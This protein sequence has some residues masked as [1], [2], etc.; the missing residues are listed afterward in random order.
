MKC[1]L[2]KYLGREESGWTG[3]YQ[4]STVVGASSSRKFRKEVSKL[5]DEE[6]FHCDCSFLVVFSVVVCTGLMY[7]SILYF[8]HKYLQ[9]SRVN[10]T[11]GIRDY[12]HPRH[13]VCSLSESRWE[14]TGR[15]T[16]F[17]PAWFGI[18]S[19]TSVLPTR[20]TE[21]VGTIKVSLPVPNLLSC[22]WWGCLMLQQLYC[23]QHISKV[24]WVLS[25]CCIWIKQTQNRSPP[26]RRGEIQ[27]AI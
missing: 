5:S 24:L 22:G 14:Q 7:S 21:R 16:S 19:F 25:H 9:L 15:V 17:V 18:G 26:Q 1:F 20:F 23:L 10:F 12:L 11:K 4:P 3:V 27:S 8:L 13:F 6:N 2:T